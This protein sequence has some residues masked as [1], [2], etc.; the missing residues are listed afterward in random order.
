MMK[1][2][3]LSVVA[4]AALLSAPA[5]AVPQIPG[6]AGRGQTGHR[7]QWDERAQ[8]PINHNKGGEEMTKEMLERAFGKN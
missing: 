1:V 7:Y 3:I 4:V 8:N 6:Q 2:L 5:A